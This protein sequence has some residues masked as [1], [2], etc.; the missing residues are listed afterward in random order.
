M[1]EF[2]CVITDKENLEFSD[3]DERLDWEREQKRLDREWY[4]MDEGYDNDQNPFSGTSAAYTRKKEEEMEQRKKKRMSAQQR[5]INKV[6]KNT[7]LLNND[8]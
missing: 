8:R 7:C 2:L 6:H 3:E 5:Q 1:T 4:N